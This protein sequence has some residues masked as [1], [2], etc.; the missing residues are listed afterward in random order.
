MNY[1]QPI[2]GSVWLPATVIS[3]RYSK[4]WHRLHLYKSRLSACFI[5][6]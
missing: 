5:Q 2:S 6:S 3:F 4:S 1:I